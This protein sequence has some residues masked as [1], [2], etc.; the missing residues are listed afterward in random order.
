[1]KK[2]LF[3]VVILLMPVVVSAESFYVGEDV[4][5]V[6]L[7][8]DKISSQ[9]YRYFKPAYRISDNDLAYCVEPSKLINTSKEYF[10][11][12]EKQWESLNVSYDVWRRLE[13]LA[14]FGYGYENH[15]TDKWKSITQYL[16]WQSVLP[17][18]W[19]LTFTD[20]FGGDFKNIHINETEEIENLIRNFET[21]PSFA[22]ENFKITK[23][24]KLVLKDLNNV[25][26]NYKLVTDSNLD[27]QMINNELIIDGNINGDFV[28]EFV[29]GDFVPTKL[30]LTDNAQALIATDGVPEKSFSIKV[31]VE[32]GNLLI[33][34][35]YND[36]LD[37][38][39]VKENAVYEIIDSENNKYIL[40]TDYM[41]ELKVN[42]LP[43][44]Q[45]TIKELNPSLGYEKDDNIYTIFIKDNEVVTLEIEPKLIIKKINI[46]K[47]YLIEE[48]NILP[49]EVDSFFS[50]LKD[51]KY[52]LTDKT[53]TAGMVSFLVP[54]GHYVI[55]QD[56]T[57]LGYKLMEDYPFF[58][59]DSNDE[60]LTFVNYKEVIQ[61]KEESSKDELEEK[62][63]EIPNVDIV[64]D[65]KEKLP[66]VDVKQEKIPVVIPD[67]IIQPSKNI[68]VENPNTG[69]TLYNYSFKFVIAGLILLKIIRKMQ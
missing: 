29:R 17:N 24:N 40:T 48:H 62:E 34:R 31:K 61:D 54:Y 41:G 22:G 51:E 25:L 3:L 28:L 65:D 43:V 26:E 60:Y 2:V 30:Y 32:S 57:L 9:R 8:L 46:I 12:T 52:M 20:G 15:N 47:K 10:Y 63:E 42:D 1:M 7:Y 68:I 53:D 69:D 39:S 38:E 64:E 50:V 45:V 59:Q 16:L 56:S 18:G 44:G 55:K 4:K 36:Y 23:N 13:L 66:E 27:V 14:Y 19:F 11:V 33:K 5:D 58:V 6:P 37:N 49:N 67:N 21:V 35:G